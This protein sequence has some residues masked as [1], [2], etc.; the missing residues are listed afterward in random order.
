MA[1]NIGDRVG[2][3]EI[4]DVLGAGGMGKVYKV[5]N[6]ISERVEAMKVLLPNLESD[7]DLAD[8][9]M[10]EIKVQASLQHQNI[11]ALHT[12]LRVNNQLLMLIE[13]VEGTSIEAELRKGPIPVDKAVD[14]VSQ[15]LSALSYAHSQGVV[16]RDIKP[17][18][19]ML[20]PQSTIKLMDF[21]I[22]RLAADRRL[23]Q[24][25][26]T[27]GSLYYMS[28]EQIQ[29]AIDLD[30]RSDL[31]SLGVTLYEIVTARR[32]F[33]GD[34]DYSIMAAHLSSNP[35]PPVQID[36]SV[37]Q[38]LNEVILM[39][40]QKDPAQRFQTADA[41]RSALQSVGASLK[42]A[43]AS[44]SVP[45]GAHAAA[46]SAPAVQQ[47]PPQY[48]PPQVQVA[49]PPPPKSRRGLW[50]AIGSVATI[51]GLVLI[52]LQA[53][54]F[55]GPT[56]ASSDPAATAQTT[57]A[58]TVPDPQPPA[59]QQPGA[60]PA[61][62][63]VQPP[64]S[65]PS[66]ATTASI[67]SAQPPVSSTAAQTAPRAGART[68][69][70]SSSMLSSPPPVQPP[71][72][73]GMQT[74]PTQQSPAQPLAAQQAPAQQPSGPSQ[75][76]AEALRSSREL[77]MMLGTRANSV[78]ASLNTMKQQQ[79]RMGVNMNQNILT[80]EQRMEFFLD[81]AQAAL[82]AGDAAR[83]KRNLESAERAL[84]TIEKFL[85]R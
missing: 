61:V 10:R 73:Q 6:V 22:A 27:V 28:P 11:A 50:I 31:Y 35:V 68:T 82:K 44:P 14:Y 81:D 38:L 5:R 41:L 39:A 15:V 80:A 84:E 29:G 69:A 45:V 70:A 49:A 71:S 1:Y 48:V 13:F 52:A 66:A 37:P 30:A 83:A 36:P 58:T 33:Q 55:F 4:V 23:T 43:P 16:H 67:P 77:L 32:P 59:A 62:P 8:R 24:T 63:A 19:I 25:G 76:D 3:Y 75:A 7:R 9:F 74:P 78:K 47:T 53:P 12:A 18:N 56:S 85:G 57:P 17:A 34:S 46:A 26:R 72:Q 51:A 2:D 21:G 40:I 60:E 65:Q 64:A 54:R 79:A 20:T 42:P